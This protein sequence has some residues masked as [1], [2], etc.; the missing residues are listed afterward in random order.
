[1]GFSL[2]VIL[3][4]RNYPLLFAIVK[5]I[6]CYFSQLCSLLYS[7]KSKGITV[8]QNIKRSN[9]RPGFVFQAQKQLNEK[10]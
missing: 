8:L 4:C 3:S 5:I 2:K 10:L 9:G 1:M 7:R 6:K